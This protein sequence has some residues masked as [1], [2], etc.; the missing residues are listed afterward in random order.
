MSENEA[1]RPLSDDENDNA[2]EKPAKK[3]KSGKECG[4]LLFS[5][6]TDY[7]KRSENLSK[8]DFVRWSPHR[9]KVLEGI[10]FRD[11]LSSPMAYFAMAITE[12]GKLYAWG[13]NQ[14]GQLGMGD[15]R[16]RN[17]PTLV[18]A[19]QDHNVVAVAAGRQ[20]CLIL[21]DTGDVYGCGNNEKG[22]IGLGKKQS[23][24][25]PTKVD[26]SD[27]GCVKQVRCG[28]EF[29]LFLNTDGKVFVVGC[30]ENGHCGQGTEDR[31]ITGKKEIF[32]NVLKPSVID[33]FVEREDGET[34]SHG[35]PNI[36]QIDCGLEHSCAIDDQ[37]RMFTWGFGGYGRLGHNSTENELRPRLMK[38]WYRTTGRADG[39]IVRVWCGGT[40]NLVDTIVEKCK[41][42]FGQFGSNKEANMYPKFMDDLQGW[43]V[44]DIATGV[45]GYTICAD[46][47][48]IGS[49][50]SPGTGQLAM[51]PTKKASQPPIL[52]KTLQDNYVLRTGQGYMHL[53]MIVRDTSEKDQAAIEKFPEM[54]LDDPVEEE[55]VKK[56]GPAAKQTNGK[57]A[58][59]TSKKK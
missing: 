53:A 25:T 48:V 40:F 4:T 43:N 13:L 6:L 38:C 32:H 37:Q 59:K 11:V 7:T 1:K 44:R 12:D 22:Q 36:V 19:L 3:I 47:Q 29:S 27:M 21:T 57:K 50:P 16:S 24:S 30:P 9:Y 31:E 42:T 23:V 26:N 14:K 49:Q 15:E 46:D 39:G 18:K 20:H 35:Q 45:S 33:L 28:D 5:G 58:T 2:D 8:T 17:T 10:R 52:I 54:E 55:P 34:V 56:K 51:G 41:Y